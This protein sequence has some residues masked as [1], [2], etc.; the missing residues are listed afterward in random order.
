MRLVTAIVRFVVGA[1]GVILGGLTGNAAEPPTVY[2]VGVAAVDIT[3]EYPVRLSGFGF[4]RTESEGVTQPIWA[5]ALAIASS[6]EDPTILVTTDNLGIPAS[7][8]DE[9]AKRLAAKIGLKRERLAITATHTHTAPM[10]RGVAPTLFG[11]PIPDEHWQHIDRYTKEL[12][13]CL[14][15]VALDAWKNRQPA[16]LTWGVGTAK[17]AINRRTKGGPVDHDLPVLVV[18]S[19]E[20]KVRAIY[21][22]YACHCVTLSNN[23]ISGD[24]AGYAQDLIERDFPNVVALCSVGCGADSN[25]SSG[26]TGDKTDVALQ[27]GAEIAAEVKRLVN[28][29]LAPVTGP[30]KAH[31]KSITL[32]FATPPAREQWQEKAKRTDAIGYHAQV[33]LAR[34]DRGEA[35]QSTLEYP[36]AS[37]TF[38]DSLAMVFLPGEVVVDYSLRLKKELDRRR[39]WINA[40]ANDEPC[41]IP[42]ERVLKEGGYE[43]GGAMVY[44]DRPGPLKAG[45]E[46]QIITAVK[47]PL[48][49]QFVSPM[50]GDKLQGSVPPSPQQAVA[51]LQTTPNLRVELVVAEPLITSPVAIDFARD[52][53]VFVCEMYDYPSGRHGA[54][55]PY[56]PESALAVKPHAASDANGP[57]EGGR[58]RL[59]RDLNGDGQFDSSTL[60]LEGI[61]FPTG[62]TVYRNGV[63]VCAAPDILY[64]EDT[65]GDDRADVV[66]TLFT[67]FG[68][69]NFQARVN[70]LTYGLDGW[71]YGSCGLF[72]G[73]IMN[74]KGEKF[75][76]GDRDFSFKPETGELEPAT[77]RTQQGRVRDDYGNWFGCDNSTLGYHYPLVEQDLQRNPFV[78]PPTAR[79]NLAQSEDA[80]RLLPTSTGAQRFKLSGPSGNVTAAC[81]LGLYRDS[82]L[83]GDYR[84]DA[85]TCEPV[86]LLV[87]RLKPVP[88]GVSFVGERPEAEAQT[89]FLR[90]TNGWFR[91]VQAVTGPDGALWVIDMSRFVIEHP[92]WI[93]A[94]DLARVDVRAGSEMGRIYRIVPKDA[95]ARIPRSSPNTP[96]EKVDFVL[97]A[98]QSGNGPRIDQATDLLQFWNLTAESTGEGARLETALHTHAKSGSFSAVVMLDRMQRLTPDDVL[99]LLSDANP[100]LRS[101]AIHF[102]TQFLHDSTAI[103]TRLLQLATDESQHVR[104][105]V[106]SALGSMRDRDAAAVL[107]RIAR[108]DA[109]NPY[110]VAA[111]FSSVHQHNLSAFSNA[112]LAD[113]AGK[114][115]PPS[116][117]VPLVSTAMGVGDLGPVKSALQAVLPRDQQPPTVWQWNAMA[118]LMDALA[119]RRGQGAIVDAELQ[120]SLDRI[121]SLAR[122]LVS[123]ATTPEPQRLAAMQVLGR[124]PAQH[125]TDLELLSTL[126]A[127]QH[128]ATVQTAAVTALSRTGHRSVPI[129]LTAALEQLTPSV[130][131]RVIDV[132]L[133]RDA[134]IPFC[135][136]A[137]AE[138]KLP[139]AILDAARRQRLITHENAKLREQAVNVLGDRPN[140]DRQRVVDLY[141]EALAGLNGDVDR[142]RALFTKNCAQCHKLN[143]TG[144]AVG[145]D[146]AMVANKTPSFL[147]QELLDPNRNLDSR[148]ATYIA[149]TQDGRTFTGLLANESAA[150]LTLVAAEGKQTTIA[151]AE[152]DVFKATGRSLMPEG[153]EKDLPP[154]AIADVVAFLSTVQPPSKTFPGNHPQTITPQQG[155]LTLLAATSSIRGG[156][157]CFEEPHQNI[158]YWHANTD[159]VSWNVD[160]PASAEYDVYLHYACD[161]SS[162]G[163]RFLLTGVQ[164]ELKGTI[165]STGAWDKFVTVKIGTVSAKAG[166][167][168]IV[169]RPDGSVLQGALM[170]LKGVYCVPKGDALALAQP[171]AEKEKL[172]KDPRELA[173]QILDGTLPNAKREAVIQE[174]VTMAAD[175]LRAMTADGPWD[176]KEEY[177]RIPWI[178]RVAIASGKRNQLEELAAV[179]DA[180]LPLRDQPLRD[181]QAVVIGG[182]VINGI[183]LTGV[184]PKPRIEELLRD[185]PTLRERWTATIVASGQMADNE[186]VPTGTRYD[187]LRIIAL[188]EWPRC[189]DQ[190][191][192]YLA[193]GV[194]AELQ[195][196]A[197]SGLS[198]VDQPDTAPLLVQHLAGFAPRNRDLAVEA[199]LRNESRATA[200]LDALERK[201]VDITWL[202]D[203]HRQ[204]LSQGLGNVIAERAEKLLNP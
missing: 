160:Q 149:V 35:L 132:L 77:G 71:M 100:L 33:Q 89:E 115:L 92:R 171:P 50:D 58:I 167:S 111:V 103:S 2:Q 113:L 66:R 105:H 133:S 200:L 204:R 163:N 6:T 130:Q 29:F 128:A 97:A 146:L 40:Y 192:K 110:M 116:L 56:P 54:A 166:Q 194:H 73:T 88:N 34:L 177:R 199:L 187:A 156:E 188:D 14:E 98:L 134:W 13:D 117:V 126:L 155:R 12:T 123:T 170:D 9:V 150:Q 173:R 124:V 120:V 68:I 1:A 94:D 17:F 159:H 118:Q 63:L 30:I 183:S 112:L 197:V 122:E 82:L 114:E 19:L 31:R 185:H 93:P 125:E 176:S 181:W 21:V 161:A 138:G 104:L 25:P 15:Q 26:V 27:Q 184:W 61:P 144:H 79:I 107:A 182:G 168:T 90:S 158:G 65:N 136:T 38:G 86:N 53:S 201:Q 119:K 145:P 85:F 60:F 191:K 81:G 141:R 180:S 151:R 74:F 4:R 44:Y 99:P 101:A 143:E 48:L 189:R 23:K 76:L 8:C 148:Y 203:A 154:Q 95:A 10:L 47:E 172:S 162:A 16:H 11:Q 202:K 109:G 37:W 45:L 75:E 32:D 147:M 186:K 196:G 39:L 83:A 28:G 127:P 18:K 135:L 42:S 193:A 179:M 108:H 102:T 153:L 165:A 140:A 3:P 139:A 46:D 80:R 62:V 78:A 198:D 96:A 49:P 67:G 69:G 51:A 57:A 22:S 131:S 36:V 84:G 41:Y 43:G 5:K 121:T 20:G 91:P 64:A 175:L 142:G 174:H 7:M 195:M 59:V 157:I 178:W 129:R 152:L 169:L 55:A 72:G 190:L 106:A 137:I 87:H 52:G 164:P 70:S 24:W